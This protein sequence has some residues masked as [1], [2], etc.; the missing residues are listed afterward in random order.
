TDLP[1]RAL[2]M[3]RLT[4]SFRRANR[5]FD[6]HFAVFYLDFDRFKLVNDSFGHHVGDEL[7]VQISNR[8][9]AVLRGSDTVARLGGD[10]FAM[11][12]EEIK[13]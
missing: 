2:F 6:N 12:I 4:V 3:N 13:D 7:L 11:L 1:N 9:K 8:L 10:E 5:Q